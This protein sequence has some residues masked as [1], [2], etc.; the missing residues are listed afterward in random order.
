MQRA[1]KKLMALQEAVKAAPS[2]CCDSTTSAYALASGSTMR[3]TRLPASSAATPAH[4]WKK[5]AKANT[6]P[7]LRLPKRGS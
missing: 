4:S 6:S 1:T 7:F 3:H 2:A 5:G